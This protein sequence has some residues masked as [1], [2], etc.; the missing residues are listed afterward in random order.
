MD[1][2]IFD[3]VYTIYCFTVTILDFMHEI[4]QGICR[5]WSGVQG[6]KNS[7]IERIR[8]GQEE[9]GESNREEVKEREK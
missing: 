9:I 4:D 5:V 6:I 3:A 8:S 1:C 7:P 2:A